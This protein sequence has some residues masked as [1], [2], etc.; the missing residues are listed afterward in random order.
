MTVCAWPKPS[1]MQSWK[2]SLVAEVS[3][4]SGRPDEGWAWI[5]VVENPSTTL[6][7]LAQS[8]EDWEVY[9]SKLAIAIR[10]ILTGDPGMRI[11]R[12]TKE[13]EVNGVRIRGRQV[14]Y[15]IRRVYALC[16]RASGSCPQ[17]P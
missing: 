1:Q 7:L 6:E 12:T 16:N 4:P 15:L 9:D 14:V 17:R 11:K 13:M 5:R 3:S 2:D 10:R 8:G